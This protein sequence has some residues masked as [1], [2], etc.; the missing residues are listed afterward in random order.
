VQS[1]NPLHAC[2]SGVLL[3]VFTKKTQFILE[4]KNLSYLSYPEKQN[5]FFIKKREGASFVFFAHAE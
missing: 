3:F 4:A 2:V 1:Q 5:I